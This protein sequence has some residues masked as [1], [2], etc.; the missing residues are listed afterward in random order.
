MQNVCENRPYFP[1]PT[2]PHAGSTSLRITMQAASS[3]QPFG[4]QPNWVQ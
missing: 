2:S 4:W 3:G 1:A